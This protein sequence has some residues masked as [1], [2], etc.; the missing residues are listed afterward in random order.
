MVC[1]HR[2]KHHD[3]ITLSATSGLLSEGTNPASPEDMFPLVAQA[4]I[5]ASLA[6]F[7][8]AYGAEAD[9]KN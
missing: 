9:R 6:L 1:A 8:S 3:R 7:S 5:Y 2:K 4:F